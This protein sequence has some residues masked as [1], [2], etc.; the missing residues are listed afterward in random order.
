M[1]R[2]NLN[3]GHLFIGYTFAAD[4]E[5]FPFRYITSHSSRPARKREMMNNAADHQR[6]S[7]SL[8]LLQSHLAIS[9]L[10]I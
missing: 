6:V 7:R 4:R 10:T 8:S 1:L 9:N 5:V 2:A 3:L